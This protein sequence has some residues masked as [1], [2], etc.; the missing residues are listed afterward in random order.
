MRRGELEPSV[1]SDDEL[2]A[3]RLH[4]LIELTH[5]TIPEIDAAPAIIVNRLLL[6]RAA[7]I[8][9]QRGGE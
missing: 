5:W 9:A 6:V 4:D 3:I 7:T 1:L 2:D 8:D